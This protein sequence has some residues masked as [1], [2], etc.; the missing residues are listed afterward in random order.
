MPDKPLIGVAADHVD[1]LVAAIE[2][3][4]G[5]AQPL[6]SGTAMSQD[7]RLA[8]LDALVVE[9]RWSEPLIVDAIG[10][11][12]PLLAV[13]AGMQA[14]NTVL[15]GK[16]RQYDGHGPDGDGGSSYHRVYITP[17][18]RLATV[19]G[20]GGFVRVN[21]RHGCAVTE[22]DKSR[23]LL[24]SAYSLDDGVIEAVENPD[25]DWLIGVQF[26]PERALELPPHFQRLFVSLVGAATAR[27]AAT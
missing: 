7:G 6:E 10:A 19:V 12:M 16:T 15:G 8:G 3:A 23:R 22:A 27:K 26:H 20:S 11:S 14:L 17:G 13:G 18:S 24:A 4:G 5:L 2:R 25:H 1:D 21:S 9:A